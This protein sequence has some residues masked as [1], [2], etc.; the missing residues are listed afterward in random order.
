MAYGA[1]KPIPGGETDDGEALH[2]TFLVDRDGTIRW[3][4]LGDRPF[5]DIDALLAALDPPAETRVLSLPE[6]SDGEDIEQ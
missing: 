5:A 6:L 3:A 4:Y 1:W 2:G